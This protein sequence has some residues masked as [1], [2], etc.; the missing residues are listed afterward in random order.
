MGSLDQEDYLPCMILDAYSL[1]CKEKEPCQK[2][3]LS[4]RRGRTGWQMSWPQVINLGRKL[5]PPVLSKGLIS[6]YGRGRE[7]HVAEK[8]D[9]Q[10][11]KWERVMPPLFPIYKWAVGSGDWD[12]LLLSMLFG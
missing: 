9:A 10:S 7:G 8:A 11:P 3:V 5:H 2:I 4:H 6:E 1:V 12:H